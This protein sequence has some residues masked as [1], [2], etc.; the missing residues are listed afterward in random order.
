MT[1]SRLHRG[2]YNGKPTKTVFW[3]TLVRVF[4]PHFGHGTQVVPSFMAIYFS[5]STLYEKNRMTNVTYFLWTD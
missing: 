4:C 1:L 2:Q 5:R 3:D